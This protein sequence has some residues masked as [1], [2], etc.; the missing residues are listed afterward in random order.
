MARSL[1]SIM[2]FAIVIPSVGQD[3]RSRS[4][5]DGSYVTVNGKRLWYRSEG[6][7]SP[8]ILIPGG[9][10][11]SHTYLWPQFSSLTKEFRVIYFDPYGRGQS[12]WADDPSEYTFMRDVDEIEGLRLALGLEKVNLYGHS[13]GAMVAQA[14]ALKYPDSMSHLILASPFHSAE[15][16]Q[17]GN[18]DM[19]NSELQNQAPEVWNRLQEMRRGGHLSCEEEYQSVQ[20]EAP[21]TSSYYYDVSNAGKAGDLDI[22]L[23]VYCQLA[24]AD[25]DITLGGDLASLDF[26][27]RLK[28]I[29]APTLII[30]GR[31]DHIAIPRFVVQYKDLMPAARLEIFEKSGHLQF[32]EEPEKHTAIVSEF[33]EK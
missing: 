11:A 29:K 9:P 22:N 13:Y 17:K 18:N 25:A 30:A 28:D 1:A 14:Y 6:K 26:R 24:G 27:T 15:M 7:G 5:P 8:L 12:D 32:V 10:G 19:W 2:L 21:M 16:W 20:D 3:K 23:E 33:L 4:E 31:W